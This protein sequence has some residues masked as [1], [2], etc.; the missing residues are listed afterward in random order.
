MAIDF[1]DQNG[2]GEVCIEPRRSRAAAGVA[3]LMRTLKTKK[4]GPIDKGKSKQSKV[5]NST[6][7]GHNFT[8]SL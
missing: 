4:K 5:G 3:K 1:D 2:L 7:G 6:L 8:S